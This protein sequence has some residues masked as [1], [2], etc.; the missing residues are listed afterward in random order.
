MKPP[1]ISARLSVYVSP[2]LVHP[3]SLPKAIPQGWVLVHNFV[4]PSRRQGLHGA[5]YW[6]QAPDSE[7]L[8][9]CDCGW[10]AELGQHYR[11]NHDFM[12]KTFAAAFRLSP[13]ARLRLGGSPARH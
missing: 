7:R 6:L 3:A 9:V 1:F 10:A 12:Q 11:V 2:G 5:S 8:T 4:R 13:P